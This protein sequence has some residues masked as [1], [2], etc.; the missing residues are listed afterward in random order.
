MMKVRKSVNAL[1][2]RTTISTGLLERVSDLERVCQCP[3]RANDHFYRETV[4]AEGV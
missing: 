4:Y 1:C 3:M 2:G